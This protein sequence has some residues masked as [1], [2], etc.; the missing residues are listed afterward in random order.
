MPQAPQAPR[1]ERG[2]RRRNTRALFRGRHSRLVQ[3]S[4]LVLPFPGAC[5][6]AV[7]NSEVIEHI[8]DSPQVFTEMTRVLRPGGTLVLG[9]P[10][11]GRWLW[12]ILE[13]LYGLLLP[14]AYAS[15]HITHYTRKTLA[16]RLRAYGY[17]LQE[18]RYVGFCE[19][20]FRARRPAGAGESHRP[21]RSDP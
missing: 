10:D 20:I 13:W 19:M 8:V 11:Y 5:F 4:A 1:E 21:P 7:V 3:A 18:V 17:D 6:D 16:E 15:E 2:P 9:T 14:G 12:W